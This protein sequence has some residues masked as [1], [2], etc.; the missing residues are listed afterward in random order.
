MRNEDN[1]KEDYDYTNVLKP[2]QEGGVTQMR[3]EEP[4]F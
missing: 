1:S 4:R 3:K 2:F